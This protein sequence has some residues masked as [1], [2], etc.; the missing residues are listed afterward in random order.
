MTSIDSATIQPM[1]RIPR[2]DLEGLMNGLAV[3]LVKLAEGAV[4]Q[5]WRLSFPGAQTPTILYGLAGTGRIRVGECTPIDLLPHALI[6]VPGGQPFFVEAP[7]DGRAVWTG[8][9]VVADTQGLELGMLLRVVAGREPHLT[10][11][12]GYFSATFGGC[13]DLFASLPSSIVEQFEAHDQLDQKLRLALAEFAAQEAGTGAMTAAFLKQVLIALL[14]RSLTSRNVW[15]ERFS[16]LS[17]PPIAR[18]FADMVARPGARHS[19]QSLSQNVGLS[20]SV[21]MSRFTAA[22]GCAPM[23]VLRKLRMRQAAALLTTN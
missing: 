15:A 23:A 10:F 19:V 13:I 3:S 12:C 2:S 21:F 20:R 8:S 17:D 5:G 14:R 22:L 18:A 4:N 9:T 11:V 7:V 6:I 1:R 16:M